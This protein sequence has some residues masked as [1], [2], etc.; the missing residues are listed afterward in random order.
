LFGVVILLAV[1]SSASMPLLE[2]R[3]TKPLDQFGP[4]FTQILERNNRT[5]AYL[6]SERGGTFTDSGASGTPASYWLQAREIGAATQL[7]LYVSAP[8]RAAVI[9]QAVEQC[10]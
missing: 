10:R 9:S 7:R 5:W 6:G 3:S 8:D 4:C 2:A 1:A